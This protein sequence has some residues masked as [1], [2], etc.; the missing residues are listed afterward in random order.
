MYLHTT[1]LPHQIPPA[2]AAHLSVIYFT[3]TRGDVEEQLLDRF[4]ATEKARLD[5]ERITLLQVRVI[6]KLMV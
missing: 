4:M 6:E 5:D 2:L 3:Q 1:A